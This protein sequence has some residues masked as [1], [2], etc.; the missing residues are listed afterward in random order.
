[1]AS[2]SALS[3]AQMKALQSVPDPQMRQQ[4]QMQFEMARLNELVQLFSNILKKIDEM[5]MAVIG[6]LK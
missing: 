3:G 1:M 6:N 2:S 5:N 4:L